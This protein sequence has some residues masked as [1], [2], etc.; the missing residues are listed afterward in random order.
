MALNPEIGGFRICGKRP[1]ITNFWGS[2][3]HK[4]T[5]CRQEHVRGCEARDEDREVPEKSSVYGAYL[6]GV[7]LEAVKMFAPTYSRVRGEHLQ[8]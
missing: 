7:E 6:E 3:P 8:A 1:S 2:A 4:S 5:V